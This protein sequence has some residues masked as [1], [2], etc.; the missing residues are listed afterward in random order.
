MVT[1]KTDVRFQRIVR[2][3]KAANCKPAR[4]SIQMAIR[5]EKEI[6]ARTGC[7]RIKMEPTMLYR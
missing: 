5:V 1:G 3:K 6:S 4:M 2:D 7:R